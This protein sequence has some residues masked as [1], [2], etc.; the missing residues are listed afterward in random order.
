[1]M[2]QGKNGRKKKGS[3]TVGPSNKPGGDALQG[4]ILDYP[5]NPIVEPTNTTPPSWKSS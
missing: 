2:K 3:G 1:M 4:R 5:G